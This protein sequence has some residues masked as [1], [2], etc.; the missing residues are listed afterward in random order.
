MGGG[1]RIEASLNGETYSIWSVYA[2]AQGAV[3]RSFFNHLYNYQVAR[4]MASTTVMA[5]D[6]NNCVAI[7]GRDTL[8]MPNYGSEGVEE[9]L[10]MVT[11]KQQ[12]LDTWVEV[13]NQL[14]N[15]FTRYGA[16]GTNSVTR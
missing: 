9:L 10:C 8:N 1:V 12:L 16:G 2:P 6:F 4:N 14:E 13:D 3:R 7:T 5:G 15:S 11:A